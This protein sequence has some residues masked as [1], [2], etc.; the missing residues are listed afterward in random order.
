MPHLFH[1][2]LVR[3]EMYEALEDFFVI[4][5]RLGSMLLHHALSKPLFQRPS[6]FFCEAFYWDYGQ[7]A[8]YDRSRRVKAKPQSAAGNGRASNKETTIII[9][10]PGEITPRVKI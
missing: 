2:E 3:K 8:L 6:L 1:D 9:R 4:K 7:E 5:S 10:V